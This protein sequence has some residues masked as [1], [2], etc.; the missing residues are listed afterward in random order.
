LKKKIPLTPVNRAI[1]ILLVCTGITLFFTLQNYFFTIYSEKEFIL[2]NTFWYQATYFYPWGILFI[3][4][5]PY[6]SRYK[7]ERQNFRKNLTVL[8]SIGIVTA[9]IHRILFFFLHISVIAPAKLAKVSAFAIVQKIIGEAFDGFIIYW[10]ILGIFLSFD[11]YN[12]YREHKLKA[13]K[14]ETDLAKAEMQALKMQLHPHFLFNT[15]HAISTLME[16]DIKTARRMIAKLSELLRQTLDN[17]GVQFVSFKQELDFLKRYLEI[18][19]TRFHDRLKI[20]FDI[21][22]GTLNA[23]VPNLI[24]QPIVENAIKH[25]ISP[26]AEGGQIIISSKLSNDI[27]TLSVSDDGNET[28]KSTNEQKKNG[29]GLKNTKQRLEQLYEKK[30]SFEII[31]VNGFTVNIEIPFQK[32]IEK[33]DARS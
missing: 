19:E 11:Y 6:L 14:L 4:L 24:M 16:E 25:G 17:I 30:F 18:E 7:L 9:I 3:I 27:L 28:R 32:Y 8:I 1:I 22:Q 26:K 5:L 21:D 20:S 33:L 31:K 23:S 10:L 2:F 29:L 12:R 13:A 15:L